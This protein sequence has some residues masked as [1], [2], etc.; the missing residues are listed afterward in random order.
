MSIKVYGASWCHMTTETLSC[1]KR[2]GVPFDYVD[3]ERDKESAKWVRSHNHG[4]ERKP[5]LD[6]DGTILVEPDDEELTETLRRL[7]LIT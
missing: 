5:T 7:K 1:L 2:L 6:I 4:K 3:I